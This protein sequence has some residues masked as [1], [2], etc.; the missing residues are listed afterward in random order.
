MRT[1]LRGLLAAAALL[2]SMPALAAKKPLG[3][4]D[5]IDLNR[6]GV[7]ELMRLPGVGEKRAQAIVAARSRQ[8]F[9]KPEDVL[10]VKGIGPAWLARV[11]ANILVGPITAAGAAQA[12]APAAQR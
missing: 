4:G 7:A 1:A 12:A 2:A 3:P 10:A 5:R 11:R 6:A 9:R 8:P